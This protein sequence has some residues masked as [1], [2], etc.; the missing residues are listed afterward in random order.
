MI[1]L[2]TFYR[3]FHPVGNAVHMNIYNYDGRE[4]KI[5]NI[6]PLTR[7]RLQHAALL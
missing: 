2:P 5:Q 3:V 6:V 1:F 7:A 4:Q